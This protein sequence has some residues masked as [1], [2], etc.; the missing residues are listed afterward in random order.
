ML[1][2]LFSDAD[3]L[4]VDDNPVNIEL[5]MDLLEDEGYTNLEGIINPLNV[6]ARIQEKRPDLI[7]L[8][9]RMPGMN[10]LELL[11]LL[12]QDCEETAIA[13]I[14]LTA[15]IDEKTRHQA[16][17][18]G[19]QDFLTKPFN[20]LE[21]LQR[22]HNTLQLQRLLRERTAR[23]NLLEE[24]VQSRT[25]DL[26]RMSRQDPVT[27]LP[28]RHVI[29]ESL[30]QAQQKG[31][32][33]LAFFIAIQGLD[34]INRLHGYHITDDAMCELSKKIQQITSIKIRLVGV[35]SS[36]KWV[37]LCESPIE[38]S[39]ADFIAQQL[40]NIIEAP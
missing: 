11:E 22:I 37:V 12:K 35:W 29:L 34:E 7:L 38:T 30:E 23:A 20:H 32:D 39:K 17:H 8:D 13:V 10:G 5:L 1:T 31:K 19:A 2:N 18:L 15:Q 6:Q 3:I 9:I 36:D 16:L 33:V 28:N 14:V 40:L 27:D 24:L 4:I 26:A 25:S 21:V